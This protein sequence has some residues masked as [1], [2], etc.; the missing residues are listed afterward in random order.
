MIDG[1]GDVVYACVAASQPDANAERRRLEMAG[2]SMT[3][4]GWADVAT[5]SSGFEAD[6]AI[7]NLEAAGIHAVRNDN[8]TVGIFGPGFQGATARGVTVRVAADSLD[9][10][11]AVLEPA[12]DDA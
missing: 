10:A 12:D 1:H 11:R 5:Y 2:D 9:E 6:L 8:D 3:A 7:A 4:H